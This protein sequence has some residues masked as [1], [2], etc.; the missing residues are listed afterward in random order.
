MGIRGSR[1]GG[2]LGLGLSQ[3]GCTFHSPNFPLPERTLIG[4][5]WLEIIQVWTIR[6]ASTLLVVGSVRSGP[7][8]G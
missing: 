4:R 3:L 6:G 1:R 8:S 2:S 7:I 5:R